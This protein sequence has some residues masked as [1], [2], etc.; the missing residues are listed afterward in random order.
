MGKLNKKSENNL[1]RKLAS[2]RIW[3][4]ELLHDR[5]LHYFTA[6]V[7]SLGY[8]SDGG[9]HKEWNTLIKINTLIRTTEQWASNVNLAILITHCWCAN[10]LTSGAPCKNHTKWRVRFQQNISLISQKFPHF[11]TFVTKSKI[12]RMTDGWIDKDKSKYPFLLE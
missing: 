1:K 6:I 9:I 2:K 11:S 8:S 7:I 10:N 5:N 12:F 3:T 4:L